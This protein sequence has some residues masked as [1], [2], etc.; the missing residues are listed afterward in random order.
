MARPNVHYL[1]LP[2]FFWRTIFLAHYLNIRDL[3]MDHLYLDDPPMTSVGRPASSDTSTGRSYVR[4][5]RL[6]PEMPERRSMRL[7][8]NDERAMLN[9]YFSSLYA[10]S[11]SESDEEYCP[12]EDW[13]KVRK[14]SH[15]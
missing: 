7:M 9:S 1:E 6:R 12:Q 8:N 3:L 4:G 10:D 5:S 13:K 2:H 14:D 11:G 15:G